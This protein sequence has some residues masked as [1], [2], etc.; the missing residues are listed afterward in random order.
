MWSSYFRIRGH[1][2]RRRVHHE[3]G[4][5]ME[6]EWLM[7]RER[8]ILREWSRLRERRLRRE[9]RRMR[10]GRRRRREWGILREWAML[11]AVIE[12]R[13]R[14]RRRKRGEDMRRRGRWRRRKL[15]IGASEKII[16][17]LRDRRRRKLGGFEEGLGTIEVL[18]NGRGIGRDS[19]STATRGN[20]RRRT[21]VD[22]EERRIY[23]DII[24][25]LTAFPRSLTSTIIFC[26]TITLMSMSSSAMQDSTV[27]LRKAIPLL[28]LLK[29]TGLPDFSLF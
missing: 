2:R 25:K 28:L 4:V 20:G 16:R 15:C 12:R 26:A 8:S 29:I 27:I 9:W 5:W 19:H 7:L 13:E 11:R 21:G 3:V 1:H 14:R 22:L 24:Q 18:R 23:G 17:N 6:R 10:E